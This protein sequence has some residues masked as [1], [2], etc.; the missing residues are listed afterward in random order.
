MPVP[1]ACPSRIP[2]VRHGNLTQL[3]TTLPKAGSGP[4]MAT[5]RGA[6]PL[7]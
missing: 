3:T 1:N 2:D 5:F 7:N 4:R 6:L